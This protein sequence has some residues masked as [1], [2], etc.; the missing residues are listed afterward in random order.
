MPKTTNI[1]TLNEI[2]ETT[3]V[4]ELGEEFKDSIIN[5]LVQE[6]MADI[7]AGMTAEEKDLLL[8]NFIHVFKHFLVS[9]DVYHRI[10]KLEDQ[11][12]KIH[13]LK[14]EALN[15]GGH[16][17]QVVLE[18]LESEITSLSN[19]ILD[20]VK[21]HRDN[22]PLSMV[23]KAFTDITRERYSGLNTFQII[24]DIF[25]YIF[26][27][28]SNIITAE[29]E[30]QIGDEESESV[31]IWENKFL[32]SKNQYFIPKDLLY[33]HLTRLDT[34]SHLLTG[35]I[36]DTKWGKEAFNEIMPKIIGT[37]F[38]TDKKREEV[39]PRIL[40]LLEKYESNNGKTPQNEIEGYLFSPIWFYL[41]GIILEGVAGMNNAKALEY[42]GTIAGNVFVSTSTS[43]LKEDKPIAEQNTL[44][45]LMAVVGAYLMVNTFFHHTSLIYLELE[46][47]PLHKI[48]E[49]LSLTP[50]LVK[51]ANLFL[52]EAF[53]HNTSKINE[54]NI[55][56]VLEFVFSSE[57][58][59]LYT[60][61]NYRF[62][63]VTGRINSITAEENEPLK[64][65]DRELRKLFREFDKSKNLRERIKE[66][67][68]TGRGSLAS[69]DDAIQ[70]N[71]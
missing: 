71:V 24:K 65:F 29:T 43:A 48:G 66:R 22:V 7:E 10:Q 33:D 51:L 46:D 67:N 14:E 4:G 49:R 34:S 20:Y 11:I 21:R 19:E 45:I 62:E 28:Y 30:V 63:Y 68:S 35:T 31:N 16:P 55:I 1:E 57:A 64:N 59:R 27:A 8:T 69:L 70:Q 53:P 52:R 17:N 37:V 12:R 54:D 5:I 38:L 18:K 13:A 44:Q 9:T 2:I 61:R 3:L 15:P 47:A 32:M 6:G 23:A 60:F 50:I 58:S 42:F 56:D 41:Y 36:K 25:R 40:R 39:D 26:G